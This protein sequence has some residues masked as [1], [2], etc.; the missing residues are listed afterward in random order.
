MRDAVGPF[1]P[2][3]EQLMSMPGAKETTAGDLVAEIGE[4]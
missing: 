4:K 3:S 2:W 1:T